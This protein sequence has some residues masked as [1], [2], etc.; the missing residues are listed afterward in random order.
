MPHRSP[1]KACRATIASAAGIGAGIHY[2]YPVHLTE[3]FS[4]LGRPG[5][6]PVSEAAAADMLSLPLYP[7]LSPEQQERVVEAFVAALEPRAVAG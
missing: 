2:P 6:F 5:D 1:A 3:A 7:H 4:S